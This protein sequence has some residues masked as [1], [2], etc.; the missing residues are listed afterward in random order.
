LGLSPAQV[1][2]LL[3]GK[4][5]FT[6]A[7]LSKMSE[8]LR[9]SPKEERELITQA[10]LAKSSVEISATKK[11]LIKEDEF[12]LVAQWHH[13]AIISLSKL[14]SAKHDPCWISQRLGISVNDAREALARMIRM[15]VLAEGKELKQ[16]ADL[17]NVVSETPPRAVQQYHRRILHLAAE[18]VESVPLT[19]R[20]YSAM[21]I[22]VD[23]SKIEH[24]RK[25]IEKFQGELAHVMQNKNSR[26]EAYV[27]SCQLFP[28]EGEKK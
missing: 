12:Q 6:P 8:A 1:S 19:R 16:I 11:H 18:K 9:L 3:N 4:R 24:A 23:P 25:I 17:V 15:G 10:A 13:S 14:K 27:I 26:K 2:Q 22:A 21:T 28:L 5:N 20:E 7:M